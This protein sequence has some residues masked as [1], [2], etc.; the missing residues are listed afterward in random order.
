MT[1]RL[2][3]L[4]IT[5]L[6]VSADRGRAAEAAPPAALDTKQIEQLTGAKG[7]LD[8]AAGV[9]KVS[10]ARSDLDVHTGGARMTPPLGLTSWAAFTRAGEHIAMM[11]D[12][13]LLEDQVNPAMSAALDAGLDV[14]ALHNQDRKSTRLNSSHLGISRMPSSA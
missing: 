4:A 2:L 11:G 6:L 5:A 12:I 7:Q 13:V 10:V 1:R 3:I 8:A 14:T 9:F